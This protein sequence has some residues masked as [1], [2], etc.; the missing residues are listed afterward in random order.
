MQCFLSLR[1]VNQ[2]FRNH[3]HDGSLLFS[4]LLWNPTVTRTEP[5][6]LG[7]WPG[8]KLNRNITSQSPEM[9]GL[10]EIVDFNV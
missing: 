4:Q 3:I 6:D 7:C 1:N 8:Q 10:G 2:L 9:K 5:R